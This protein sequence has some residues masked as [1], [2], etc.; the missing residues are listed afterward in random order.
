METISELSDQCAETESCT[1]SYVSKQERTPVRIFERRAIDDI[2]LVAE[3][4]HRE[5]NHTKTQENVC[6]R[7][8][9]DIVKLLPY[10]KKFKKVR[11]RRVGVYVVHRYPVAPSLLT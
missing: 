3:S 2:I 4:F 9:A 1:I 11:A 6:L 10:V 8:I 7:S 5:N